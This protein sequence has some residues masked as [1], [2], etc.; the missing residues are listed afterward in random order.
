M[1]IKY[2]QIKQSN[3][4]F[5]LNAL[6]RKNGE[7]S[8]NKYNLEKKFWLLLYGFS[9]M[10]LYF[11]RNWDISK[12]LVKNIFLVFYTFIMF[13]FFLAPVA[14]QK[15]KIVIREVQPVQQWTELNPWWCAR[16]LTSHVITI[17]VS[18]FLF[19]II[20]CTYKAI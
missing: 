17:N 6:C 3:I 7:K 16:K 10:E 11:H 15:C 8:D 2:L 4:L 18:F 20:L 19:N 14:F 1:L 12:S 9:E 5:C 13:Y